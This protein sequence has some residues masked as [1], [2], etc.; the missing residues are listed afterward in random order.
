MGVAIAN[1]C[2]VPRHRRRRARRRVVCIA[3]ARP[4]LIRCAAGL[5]LG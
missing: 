1:T 5:D 4:E 2:T 3:F